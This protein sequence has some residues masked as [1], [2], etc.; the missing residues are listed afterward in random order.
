MRKARLAGCIVLTT[1][2][3]AVLVSADDTRQKPYQSPYSVKLSHPLRELIGDIENGKR[4][5][6]KHAAAIPYADWYSQ[7]IERRFGAWGPPAKHYD[8]PVNVLDKPVEWKR[9]RTIAVGLLFVG[10]EYQHHH[11]PYWNPP[12]NWPWMKVA[13]GH[14][15]MGVDCSNFTAFV[16]NLGFGIKPSGAIGTQAHQ[17]SFSGPGLE[18]HT[19]VR[20]IELPS[21]YADLPKTLKTGD[22]LYIRKSE[23]EEIAHVVLW[24]GPIGV[25]PEDAP[26]ILDSHGDNVKDSNGVHIPAGIRLRPLRKD[27]WYFRRASHALRVWHNE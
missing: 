14:N 24:V 10:Y 27:S 8:A 6:P 7:K 16:Y 17:K 2:A 25:S 15:G 5:D 22:L 4:G 18:R 23:A 20:R 1:L 12:A 9:Q 11:I 13:A 21:A 3:P 19:A 26:L